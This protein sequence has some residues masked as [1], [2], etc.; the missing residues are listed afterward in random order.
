MVWDEQRSMDNSTKSHVTSNYVTDSHF[1]IQLISLSLHKT[2]SAQWT[3]TVTRILWRQER[4]IS[5][6]S[7]YNSHTYG[8]H[9]FIVL[10]SLKGKR[11]ALFFMLRPEISEAL[12]M[13]GGVSDGFLIIKIYPDQSIDWR[14]YFH[15]N[16]DPNLNPN[17]TLHQSMW[18]W[19]MDSN[20]SSQT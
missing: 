1:R 13:P 20:I 11:Q 12:E 14:Y 5:W 19:T 17:P 6:V 3:K 8:N 2:Q 16:T 10:D 9:A 4:E 15:S 7:G 18:M